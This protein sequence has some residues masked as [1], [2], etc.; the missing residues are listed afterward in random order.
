MTIE[1]KGLLAVRLET[2]G[3]VNG[4]DVLR[5]LESCLVLLELRRAAK[6]LPP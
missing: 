1:A 2:L 6:G 3:E 4:L 5:V